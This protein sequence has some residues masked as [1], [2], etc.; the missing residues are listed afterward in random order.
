MVPVLPRLLP[1]G[2]S[3]HVLA[4]VASHAAS[5]V[6]LW[7][8]IFAQGEGLWAMA[9]PMYVLCTDTVPKQPRFCPIR[10]V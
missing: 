10:S 3:M 2:G 9:R 5:V 8:A 1:V 6:P 4:L 7:R